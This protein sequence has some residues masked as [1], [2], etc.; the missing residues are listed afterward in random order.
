MRPLLNDYKIFNIDPKKL[1]SKDFFKNMLEYRHNTMRKFREAIKKRGEFKCPLCN[2]FSGKHFLN[3]K[4]YTLLECGRC[5]LVSPNI[6][7][8]LLEGRNV[9]DDKSYIKDTT[10]EILNTYT[11]RKNTYARERFDYL[12]KK[13]TDIPKS[14]I[15]LLDVGCGPGYFISYLKDRHVNYKGLELADF[16]VKICKRKR[17]NVEKSYLESERDKSYNIVT[18]FDV[19]EHIG[20]PIKLFKTLN[21]KLVSG[22]YIVAYTP[23]IHSVGYLL[24]QGLQNTL[25]PFQHFCFFDET[26][27]NYLCKKTGFKIYSLEYH[28][29]DVI[30][31]FYM[32]QHQDKVDYLKN[33]ENFIPIAQAIIDKQGL[34]NHMRVVFKKTKATN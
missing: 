27:L 9:Y 5:K 23:N 26:S 16:L 22:G 21:N 20:D 34:S 33:L 4:N 25:L 30:D 18:M 6:N 11:Y 29:L 3:Y 1:R 15:K 13:I 12:S 14:K 28:G 24:M 31:Y 7:F 17:L 10:Q 2:C 32:K 8:D 19:I